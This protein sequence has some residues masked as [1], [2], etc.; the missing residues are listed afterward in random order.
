MAPVADA[1]IAAIIDAVL[2]VFLDA[3]ID[4]LGI[5]IAFRA[6]PWR[7]RSGGA[8]AFAAFITFIAMAR[9]QLVFPQRRYQADDFM[10]Q[11]GYGCVL[12]LPLLL[13]PLLLLLL[14][15][16]LQDDDG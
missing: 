3:C 14:L 8:T 2:D 5:F 15:L 1:F 13:L 7:A 11:N 10:S 16:L 4:F 6:F 9:D 12:T